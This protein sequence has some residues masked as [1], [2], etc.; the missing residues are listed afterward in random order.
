MQIIYPLKLPGVQSIYHSQSIQER[1]LSGTLHVTAPTGVTV[2]LVCVYV[3][4]G[5]VMV[6]K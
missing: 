5:G 1:V 2:D 4:R 3:V 6:V